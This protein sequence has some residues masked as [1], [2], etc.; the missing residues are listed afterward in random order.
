MM[1]DTGQIAIRLMALSSFIAAALLFGCSSSV[2]AI[3]DCSV[4]GT[5]KDP[6]QLALDAGDWD[7]AIEMLDFGYCLSRRLHVSELAYTAAMVEGGMEIPSHQVERWLAAVEMSPE[8]VDLGHF[9][10]AAERFDDALGWLVL[11][12]EI[13]PD[14]R[15]WY[16]LRHRVVREAIE[17]KHS[18]VE[19]IVE[20]QRLLQELRGRGELCESLQFQDQ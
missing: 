12:S 10:V 11:A 17:S 20:I 8:F 9:Y 19:A 13:N 18:G 16:E 6:I 7:S 2:T 14:A 15:C 3:D 5:L 4:A 1:L